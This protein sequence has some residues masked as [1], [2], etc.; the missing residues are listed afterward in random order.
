VPVRGCWPSFVNR[1]GWRWSVLLGVRCR[2]WAV[3]FVCGRATSFLVDRSVGA[4]VGGSLA[5]GV[6]ASCHGCRC[7]WVVVLMWWLK[8]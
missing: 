4:V 5:L 1:G 6:D 3:D 8:K 7:V 2:L